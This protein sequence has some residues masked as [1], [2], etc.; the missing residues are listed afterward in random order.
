MQKIIE[1]IKE[2][3]KELEVTAANVRAQIRKQQQQIIAL[4]IYGHQLDGQITA[5]NDLIKKFETDDQ[6]KVKNKSKKNKKKADKSAGDKEQ[7]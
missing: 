6:K 2:T 4:E 1:E 7:K 3:K 5:Y